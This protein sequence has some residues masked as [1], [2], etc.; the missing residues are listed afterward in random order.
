MALEHFSH[1]YGYPYRH[2]NSEQCD[3]NH[4]FCKTIT[5]KTYTDNTQYFSP[6]LECAMHST[7]CMREGIAFTTQLREEKSYLSEYV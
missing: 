7:A 3:L 2:D 4:V 5:Q 1:L 6:I